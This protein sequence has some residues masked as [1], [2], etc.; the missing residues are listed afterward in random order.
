MRKLFLLFLACAVSLSVLKA[1]NINIENIQP[2]LTSM[3]NISAF[4]EINDITFHKGIVHDPVKAADYEGDKKVAANLGVYMADMIYGIGSKSLEANESLGAVLE[5]AKK[6][7]MESAFTQVLI[8]RLNSE[9][10]S[11]TEAGK[12]IDE[13]FKKGE[14]K[15]S[16]EKRTDLYNFML[17]GNYV[18]KLHLISS[19]LK[20]SKNADLPESAIAN[21]NRSLLLLMARQG[22]PLKDLS[23]LMVDYSSNIVAHRDIQML[24]KAYENLAKNKDRIVQL[25]PAEMY[26]AKEIVAIQKQIAEI[27]ERVVK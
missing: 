13:V 27:R 14:E 3:A 19:Q 16:K 2:Q 1:Q 20:Q 10:V 5:L 26:E 21:L 24:L 6:L 9:N 22:A 11:A 25:S 18:E 8:D 12:Y 17:Y 15:F 23:R 7:E 4:Y